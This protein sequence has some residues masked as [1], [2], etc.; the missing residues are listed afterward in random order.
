MRF[1]LRCGA[2]AVEDS[3]GMRI[4]VVKFVCKR[5]PFEWSFDTEY[6][7]RMMWLCLDRENQNAPWY[8]QVPRG[9]FFVEPKG[10]RPE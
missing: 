9:T 10:E 1:C 3:R 2:E 4:G 5:C 6:D 8:R 7:F